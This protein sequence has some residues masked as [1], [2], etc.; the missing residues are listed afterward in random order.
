M[1]LGL[2]ISA[3]SW[4]Q[5]GGFYKSD[6]VFFFANGNSGSV[7][8]AT[9]VTGINLAICKSMNLGSSR[10]RLYLLSI[11]NQKQSISSLKS[12]SGNVVHQRSTALLFLQFNFLFL[13]EYPNWIDPTTSLTR[14]V[15]LHETSSTDNDLLPMTSTCD[16]G[17]YIV[18][19]QC[20]DNERYICFVSSQSP[21]VTPLDASALSVDV[22]AH[23]VV[24]WF[25]ISPSATMSG[26]LDIKFG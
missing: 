3:D 11:W 8:S 17:S 21:A 16:L 14:D 6:G 9:A 19:S 15:A 7:T 1:N 5:A 24:V 26:S 10:L 23:S 4:V 13:N 2:S 20:I 25:S 18:G 12:V 22:L